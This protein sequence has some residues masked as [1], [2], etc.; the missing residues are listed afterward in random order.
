MYFVQISVVQAG[1]EGT[2]DPVSAGVAQ[3]LGVGIIRHLCL[4]LWFLHVTVT[5]SLDSSHVGS[6]FQRGIS[7]ER[8]SRQKPYGLLVTQP[9]KCHASF[10]LHCLGA[11][12]HTPPPRFRRREHRPPLLCGKHASPTVRACGMG[13]ISWWVHLRKVQSALTLFLPEKH[14]SRFKT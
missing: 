1:W 6:G 4:L 3:R 13:D 8:K 5:V 11:R 9:Q 14:F 12:S 2:A 10:L 7:W